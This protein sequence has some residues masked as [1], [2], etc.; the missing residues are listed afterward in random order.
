MKHLTIGHD[1]KQHS[2]GRHCSADGIN[3][4]Q[5]NAD[6]ISTEYY[7]QPINSTMPFHVYWNPETNYNQS[8][9]AF[10]QMQS[11]DDSLYTHTQQVIVF[12]NLYIS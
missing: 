7:G 9:H 1:S 4:G 2:G 8:Y 10:Q 3:I 12:F 6:G 5:P 11:F